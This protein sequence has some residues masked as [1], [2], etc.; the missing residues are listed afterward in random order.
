MQALMAIKLQ[1]EAEEKTFRMADG[2]S[3]I[4]NW[5][6]NRLLEMANKLKEEFKAKDAH[7]LKGH[8]LR[9]LRITR[10]AGVYYAVFSVSTSLPPFV[11]AMTVLP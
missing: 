11:D 7:R 8:H 3:R 5:L 4:C 9:N 2:Q 6:F 1:L 10:E